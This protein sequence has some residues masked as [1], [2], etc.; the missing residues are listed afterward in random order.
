MCTVCIIHSRKATVE[1]VSGLSLCGSNKDAT[2]SAATHKTKPERERE[3]ID[4]LAIRPTG[5]RVTRQ[6]NE[7]TQ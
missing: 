3:E 2:D 1:C 5:H 4:R 7:I 6:V